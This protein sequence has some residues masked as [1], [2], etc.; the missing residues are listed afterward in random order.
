MAG[1]LNTQKHPCS[2]RPLASIRDTTK[3]YHSQPFLTHDLQ[4]FTDG[5]CLRP[6]VGRLR[7]ATWGVVQ[8]NL[9]QDTFETVSYGG[10]PGI[11]QTIIRAEFLAAISAVTF[12]VNWVR[13]AWIWIDNQQ[14][15]TALQAY[16]QGKSASNFN[17]QGP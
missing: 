5:S 17:D 3:I 16:M 8:A 2:D 13:N 15:F 10:T 4:L 14:V 9:H 12:A 11:L 6:E 1:L 7:I